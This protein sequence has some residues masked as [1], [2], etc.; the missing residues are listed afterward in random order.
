MRAPGGSMEDACTAGVSFVL[1]PTRQ[2]ANTIDMASTATHSLPWLHTSVHRL[3]LMLY[4]IQRR[5]RIWPAFVQKLARR[6]RA[7]G[8]LA[9]Y[10]EA[11]NLTNGQRAL[12]CTERYHRKQCPAVA[13]VEGTGGD[14]PG[15]WRGRKMQ[16]WGC[17]L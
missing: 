3:L 16:F 12:V 11:D 14:R 1:P 9:L 7:P 10:R 6:T 4:K 8:H 5:G 2:H 15:S 17:G 13:V